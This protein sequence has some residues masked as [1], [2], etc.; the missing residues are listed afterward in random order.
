MNGEASVLLEGPA[1]EPAFADIRTHI[2]AAYDDSTLYDTNLKEAYAR[3]Y[4]DWLDRLRAFIGDDQPRPAGGRTLLVVAQ[5]GSERAPVVGQALY[6]EIDKRIERVSAIDAEVHLLLF[7]QLPASPRAAL[8]ARGT[9][10]H[11]LR[12]KVQA[13]DARSGAA[14]INTDWFVDRGFV[15][16]RAPRPFRP[17]LSAGKQQVTVEIERPLIE[18]FEYEFGPPD[19]WVPELGPEELSDDEAG[20]AWSLV[21]GLIPEHESEAV[22]ASRQDGAVQHQSWLPLLEYSP[23]SGSYILLSR[24][25]RRRDG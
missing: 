7:D 23:D 8:A 14:E 5:C 15:L 24:G 25:R 20:E 1:T 9:A 21:L 11:A 13:I 22:V 2:E 18:Q 17:A 16:H 12:G 6:F 19:K 10:R 4:A 3:W